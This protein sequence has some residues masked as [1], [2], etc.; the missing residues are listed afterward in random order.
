MHIIQVIRHYLGLT[1]QELARQAGISQPDLCEMEIKAPYGRIDKYKRLSDYLG[2]S[3]HALVTNNCALI[4]DSFFEKH[5]PK[6]YT[7]EVSGHNLEL[8]RSGEETVF[9]MEQQRLSKIN[10]S[11]SRLVLPFYKLR[12]RPGYDI[13]SFN[14]TGRPIYIE[15]KTSSEDSPDFV[16]TKQEY[17]T[18]IKL[19]DIGET[20][21]IFRF[22]NWGN[23]NQALHIFDFQDLRTSH[24][25]TPSSYLCSSTTKEQVISGITYCRERCGM[26]KGEL[27]D[28]LGIKTPHLWRYENGKQK[29]SVSVYQKMANIMGVTIDQLIADHFLQN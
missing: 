2:I 19:T 17:M 24:D 29:C 1:Q 21:Q 6:N 11:L 3:V 27:A 13:L 15:V 26:S 9:H 8:G 25:I 16:L 5:I 10:T 7:N 22:S 18:A 12:Y 20:Y 23:K 14:D 28:Y 4:P